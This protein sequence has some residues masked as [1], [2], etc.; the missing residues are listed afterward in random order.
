VERKNL[1]L[2]GAGI[3]VGVGIG[4]VIFAAIGIGSF[5]LFS[6]F[7]T[8]TGSQLLQAPA[9]KSPAP[10]F[11]LQ[12][13]DGSSFRLSD[14]RGH[15][16]L[17]NFWAT[18]CGPCQLEMPL[19]EQYYQKYNPNLVVLAVNNDEPEPDVR[20]FVTSHKLTF[21]VLL[22]PGAKVEDLYRVRAFPTTFFV[23]KSGTIRYQHIG[24]LNEGQLVQYLSQLGVGND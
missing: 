14:L 1:A 6:R 3:L 2:V 21:P 16:I 19:I 22:D 11:Q 4:M 9:Q 5:S 7:F 24:I 18:W 12:A 15:P 20:A 10:D 23:D 17:I 13:L 8:N